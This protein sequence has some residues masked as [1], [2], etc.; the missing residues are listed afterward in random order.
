LDEFFC[1]TFEVTVC[2]LVKLLALILRAQ[3]ARQSEFRRIGALL[4]LCFSF[5]AIL[6]STTK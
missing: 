2:S 3:D 1:F 5:A 6:D 4:F